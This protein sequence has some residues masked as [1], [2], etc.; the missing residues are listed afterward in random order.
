MDL[1]ADNPCD[2][3]LPVLGPQ[4][5]IVTHRQALPHKDV[6]AAIETVRDSKSAQPA[7]KLAFEFLV[8]TAARSGEVRLATWAEMDTAGRVWTIPALRMKAKR[9]HRVNRTGN[10]GDRI[11]WL[12]P[13]R[14]EHGTAGPAG[15][16]VKQLCRRLYFGCAMMVWRT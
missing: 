7:V 13:T 6:A 2:R 12:R 8:L 5:D 10:F 9:E 3:V 4:N 15:L 14:L 11:G 1:R 16:P